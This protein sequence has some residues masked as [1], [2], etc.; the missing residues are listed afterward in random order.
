M[1][2]MGAFEGKTHFSALLEDAERGE[3][4]LITK[5]GRPVARIAPI[6]VGITFREALKR[7]REAKLTLGMPLKNAIKTGRR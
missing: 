4:T 6:E 5:N 2:T 3:T 7:L 1:K